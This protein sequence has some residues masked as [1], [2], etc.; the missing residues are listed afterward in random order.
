MEIKCHLFTGKTELE[1][2]AYICGQM[3]F[4][5]LNPRT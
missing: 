2:M 1:N 3:G 5:I 4:L